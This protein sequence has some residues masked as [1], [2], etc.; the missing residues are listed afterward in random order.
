M[1]FDSS[2]SDTRKL[3]EAA[4]IMRRLVLTANE[5]APEMPWPPP[6]GSVLHQW[7]IMP[8]HRLEFTSMLLSNQEQQNISECCKRKSVSISHDIVYEITNGRRLTSKHI[9]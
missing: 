9:L 7:D 1:A 8:S 2:A 4:M 3:R 5:A 6:V